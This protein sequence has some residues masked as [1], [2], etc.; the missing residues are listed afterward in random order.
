MTH[1]LQALAPCSIE[2]IWH[3]NKTTY[4]SV[5]KSFKGI[6]LRL[7]R[8]FY[9]APTPVLE[10]I[11]DFAMHRNPEAK[12]IIKQ[13]AHLYFSK[14]HLSPKALSSQGKTY[15]LQKIFDK[16]NEGFQLEGISIGWARQSVQKRFRS[17]TFGC[18]DSVC[19]QIRINPILD[20][21]RVPLYFVEF[22]V[23]HEALHAVCPAKVDANGRC[24]VHTKEFREKE[25]LFPQ[26]SLA[27]EW[28]KTSLQF[29]KKNK[30]KKSGSYG[31][32]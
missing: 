10:A 5:R 6:S 24:L 20:D 1:P 30:L 25:K 9:E 16:I 19:R 4:I 12:G 13:M 7:H 14:T 15:D 27:K 8:L 11:I 22:I 26:F 29:F 23:Y 21:E 3:E 18:F 2:I 31:R 17:M 32:S 28:E